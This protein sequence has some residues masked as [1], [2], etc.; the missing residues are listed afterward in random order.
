[1]KRR[2]NPILVGARHVLAVLLVIGCML[3]LGCA[4]TVVPEPS[5]SPEPLA[6]P[7]R[8]VALGDSYTIGTGVA[9]AERWPNQLVAA[10]DDP[11]LELV[12]NL[13]VNGATSDDLI[14]SQLSRVAALRPD[15]VT[16]LIGVNDVVRRVP[17]GRYGDNVELIL[18]RLLDLVPAERIVVVSTPDYTLTPMGGAFGNSAQQSAAIDE[19]NAI[20]EGATRQRGIAFVDIGPIADRV[21]TDRSLVA[22]D[23]L[24]PSA[25]QYAGWV[26]QIAPVIGGK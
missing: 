4:A 20:L 14:E 16:V 7:L 6:Q 15:L 25:A 2:L 8:Y 5:P 26:E 3:P 24:H 18:G 17:A 1:L 19:F 13:G 10:L 21:A 11:Q 9:E 23:G 12:A 22:A